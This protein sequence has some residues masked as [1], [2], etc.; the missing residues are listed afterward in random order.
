MHRCLARFWRIAKIEP[1]LIHSFASV[2]ILCFTK[3]AFISF[4][5]LEFTTFSVDT[6]YSSGFAFFYDGSLDY[7]GSDHCISGIFAILIL[8]F[9]ILF[10]MLFIQLYPLKR[11]HKLLERLHLRKQILIS[12]GDVF[13]GPY[14]NGLNGT[15]DYRYF[16][17]FYLIVKMVFVN[18]YF[19]CYHS[20]SSGYNTII[21]FTQYALQCLYCIIFGGIILIFRPFYRS[22]HNF[23]EFILII[24]FLLINTTTTGILAFPLISNFSSAVWITISSV[25][26][27]L[28]LIPLV[29]LIGYSIYRIAMIF[30]NYL[31]YF[32][33]FNQIPVN[34]IN[35]E[36]EQIIE[37]ADRIEN[38]NDYDERHVQVAPFENYRNRPTHDSIMKDYD[39]NN[40]A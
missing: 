39:T 17:G 10:P 34:D 15:Y 32:R 37:F 24:I 21:F 2:Y 36:N 12:I 16:A 20:Q 23:F 6:Y 25:S 13:T 3:I 29:V 40:E 11:F 27:I 7:F 4:V 14:K 26:F 28:H 22:I 31:L 35:D 18:L 33:Q 5:L 9:L 38:P 8:I 1:S 19:F 30:K